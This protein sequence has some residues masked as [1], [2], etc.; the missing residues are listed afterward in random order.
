MPPK[1][2]Q[3]EI[4]TAILSEEQFYE[5]IAA[6]NKKLSGNHTCSE[7]LVIDVHLTWCGSCTVISSNLRTIFNNQEEPEKRLDF[8]S[9]S[10]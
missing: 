2:V 5:V 9:V 7:L 10:A 8:W 1:L 3:K 6:E 4:T